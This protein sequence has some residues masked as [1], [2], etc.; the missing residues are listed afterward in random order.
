MSQAVYGGYFHDVNSVKITS[1]DRTIERG[2][3]GRPSALSVTIGLAAKIIR[4]TTAQIFAEL[5][6]MIAAYSVDGYSFAF[7]DDFGSLQPA[8]SIDSSTAIGGVIVSKPVS[9]G[10]L[11]GAQASNF[12]WA[13]MAVSATILLPTAYQQ[14]LTFQETLTF[15]DRQGGP[16]LVRRQPARGYPFK[17]QV[18][19]RSW[20]YATQSGSLTSNYQNPQPMDP[21]FPNDFAGDENDRQITV[22]SPVT[23]RGMPMEYGLQ[24]TYNYASANPLIGK[25]NSR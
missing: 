7:Y 9:H 21:L 19:E 13:N 5:N 24:W 6:T 10:E 11:S 16:I 3:T 22:T 4:P 17:Q 8:W 12:V 2:Q 25:P 23:L 15:H 20:Y 18:T 1:L 14:F